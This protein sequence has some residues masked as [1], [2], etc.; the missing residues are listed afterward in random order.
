MNQADQYKLDHPKRD[1]AVVGIRDEKGRVFLVRT[2]KLTEWWQPIGGGLDPGD[3]SPQ[4]AA[5]RELREE[6]G[7]EI[8]P[9]DLRL[10][11]KAPY[12]FGEGT[13]YFYDL[14][15]APDKISFTIN[16]KEII[17]YKWF[18]PSEAQGLRAF[19]ATQKYLRTLI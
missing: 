9:T 12:D 11:V 4:V 13:V 17:D 14:K 3:D 5:C 15:V 1:V 18:T 7:L 2:H 6:L 10:V 8:E 19:P 16:G